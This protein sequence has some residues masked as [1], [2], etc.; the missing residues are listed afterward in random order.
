MR[1][2]LPSS[3]SERTAVEAES[4]FLPAVQNRISGNGRALMFNRAGFAWQTGIQQIISSLF[5]SIRPKLAT[6]DGKHL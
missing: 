2:L 5:C 4:L 3:E 6:A 1:T